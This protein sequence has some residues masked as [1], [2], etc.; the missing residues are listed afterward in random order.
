[1]K[2]RE[3]DSLETAG[4]RSTRQSAFARSARPPARP[5]PLQK[6][7]RHLVQDDTGS[8]VQTSRVRARPQWRTRSQLQRICVRV[9]PSSDYSPPQPGLGPV[10]TFS[11]HRRPNSVYELGQKY[12]VASPPF[13]VV[14]RVP[15]GTARAFQVGSAPTTLACPLRSALPGDGGRFCGCPHINDEIVTPTSHAHKCIT[16]RHVTTGWWHQAPRALRMSPSYHG[17][18]NS[19]SARPLLGLPDRSRQQRHTRG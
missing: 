8:M 1:M 15:L 3:P 7:L 13:G 19:P 18:R 6:T 10:H 14:T 17:P 4:R 2:G 9:F 16:E 12:H 5:Y 11:H